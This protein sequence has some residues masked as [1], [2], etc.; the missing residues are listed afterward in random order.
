MKDSVNS[1]SVG[2]GDQASLWHWVMRT[3]K[4]DNDLPPSKSN[5]GRQQKTSNINKAAGGNNEPEQ[6][7]TSQRIL[8]ATEKHGLLPMA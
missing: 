3:P 5:N 7:E 4:N 2:R 6:A 8:Q 1:L